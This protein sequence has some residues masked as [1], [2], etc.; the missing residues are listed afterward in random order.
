[1]NIKTVSQAQYMAAT[2]GHYKTALW[3]RGRGYNIR[4][5]LDLLGI[6]KGVRK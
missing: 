1:M 4:Q 2:E 6:L 5:A 3:L